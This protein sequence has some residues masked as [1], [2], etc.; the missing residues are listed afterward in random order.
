[1]FKKLDDHADLS[2]RMAKRAGADVGARVASG[3]LHPETLRAAI[4]KC[5]D[6]T[7]TCACR[8]LLQG[9]TQK[10]EIPDYCLNKDLFEDIARND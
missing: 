6:C 8:V 9:D 2:S 4:L 1:M 5:A 3:D 10:G 7:E